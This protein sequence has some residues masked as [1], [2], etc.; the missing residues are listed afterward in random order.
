MFDYFGQVIS[1]A[2]NVTNTWELLQAKTK[3]EHDKYY[4]TSVKKKYYKT[5]RYACV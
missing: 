1:R 3:R 4:K 5:I 2:E